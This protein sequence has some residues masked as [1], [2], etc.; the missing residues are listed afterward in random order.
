VKKII[1]AIIL[2]LN[3]SFSFAEKI[4]VIFATGE[5][6]PFTSEKLNGYG[7]TT[8]LVT[9]ICKAADIKPNYRFFP[10]KR[11]EIALAKG[12]A[13]G[14]FPYGITQER[15][16]KFKFSEPIYSVKNIIITCTKNI[17]TDKKN[18]YK[19]L[20]DLKGYR[21]GILNGSF[22][23]ERIKQAGIQY[24]TITTVDQAIKMLY[25][26]RIDFY[27]DDQVVIYDSIKRIFPKEV[28]YFTVLDNPFDEAKQNYVMISKKYPNSSKILERFNYG[29]NVIKKNGEYE[30]IIQKYN[31]DK[32]K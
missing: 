11:V 18:M 1:T 13:F 29:L 27:I 22:A 25:S 8:E 7:A 14:A 30:R 5:Y 24:N 17:K 6:L 3:F 12:E 10:W 23:E 15:E 26:G 20:E 21:V 32:I 9:A 4:D 2:V 31:L 19:K 28:R 16:G